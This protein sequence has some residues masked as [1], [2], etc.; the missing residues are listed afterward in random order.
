MRARFSPI[1]SAGSSNAVAALA[2]TS[3]NVS[4]L[5]L[6]WMPIRA[7]PSTRAAISVVAM[8]MRSLMALMASPIS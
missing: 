8:G 1:W 5:S 7:P 2:A 4:R 3:A 6:P